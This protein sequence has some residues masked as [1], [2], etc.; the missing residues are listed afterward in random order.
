MTHA[1]ASDAAQ[2]ISIAPGISRSGDMC[3]DTSRDSPLLL[4]RQEHNY[5]AIHD[6]IGVRLKYEAIV[7]PVGV[8]SLVDD[9]F[10]TPSRSR[11]GIPGRLPQTKWFPCLR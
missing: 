5:S 6:C 3:S 11:L 7:F 9:R 2:C 4:K 8:C 1:E 10:N